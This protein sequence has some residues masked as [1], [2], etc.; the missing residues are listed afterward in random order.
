M[1]LP[2]RWKIGLHSLGVTPLTGFGHPGVLEETYPS[3][4]VSFLE[5][6]KL[7]ITIGY[8]LDFQLFMNGANIFFNFWVCLLDGFRV[9]ISFIFFHS[10][11][12]G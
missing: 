7:Y 2:L 8:Y 6:T 5:S 3:S 10:S 1:A 11:D 12:G 9:P 4:F